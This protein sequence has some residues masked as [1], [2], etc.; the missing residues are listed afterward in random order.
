[1]HLAASD[2]QML[3]AFAYMQGGS[4]MPYEV[5]PYRLPSGCQI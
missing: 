2:P 4:Q 1:M 5:F 3:L